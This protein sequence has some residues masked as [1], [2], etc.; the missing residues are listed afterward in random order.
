MRYPSGTEAAHPCI[1]CRTVCSSSSFDWYW[2][3]RQIA[4]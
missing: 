4:F 2:S 3:G 1:D